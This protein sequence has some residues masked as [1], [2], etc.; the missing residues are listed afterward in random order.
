MPRIYP[1]FSSSSGNCT[2]ISSG[3]CG[4][5]ID[6]GASFTRIKKAFEMNGLSLSSVKA[7]FI[8]HEH[9][10]HIKGLKLFTGRTGV[11]VYS[12]P[13]TLDLLY[14]KGTVGSEAYDM[15]ETVRIC[16]M[17]V[18]SF[19]TSHDAVSP[20]GYKVSF[21]DG[22]SCCIC[23]DLGYAGMEV[24]KALMGSEAVLLEAN[25]DEKMLR[26]GPYPAELKKRIRSEIGHLSNADCAELATELVESG[27]TRLILGHLSQENNTPETAEYTVECAIAERGYQRN[28][29]YLLSVAPVLAQKGF[30]SF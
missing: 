8:T 10:D 7:V 18:S 24:K 28:K 19:D 21:S 4:I 2:Y 5:L 23:T 25:Y 6:C 1:L 22:K 30:V 16:D 12:Q 13:P 17:T 20:C 26:N 3:E 14:D 11:P 15:R 9:S 29:D 27:T